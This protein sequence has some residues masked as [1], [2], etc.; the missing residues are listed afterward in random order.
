MSVEEA[1]L[2]AGRAD[3]VRGLQGS[4]DP[5][6][7]FGDA[8]VFIRSVSATHAKEGFKATIRDGATGA[9]RATIEA[10]PAASDVAISADKFVKVG[11]WRDGSP[12]LV[13]RTVAQAGADGLK[14][15][16]TRTTLTMYA[17]SGKVLGT[18]EFDGDVHQDPIVWDGYLVPSS[19]PYLPIGGGAEFRPPRGMLYEHAS[20]AENY[21]REPLKYFLHGTTECGEPGWCPSKLVVRDMFTDKELWGTKSIPV[22]EP[23]RAAAAGKAPSVSVVAAREKL[24]LLA[25][26]APSGGATTFTAHDPATGRLISQGPTT[27]PGVKLAGP[28][29]SGVALSPDG[30]IAVVALTKGAVAWETASGRKLWEQAADERQLRPEA[31]SPK[32]VL[33]ALLDGGGTAALDAR[34]HA[35]LAEKVPTVPSFGDTFGVVR[36][37]SGNAYFVF[38]VAPPK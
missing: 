27:P 26:T 13:V 28:T 37:D 1:G 7:A 24:L 25:W 38:P 29:K 17:P 6:C 11:Y 32:G 10:K 3:I 35:L 19:G 12:A 23:I 22:P 16:T 30:G 8:V 14:A 2:C 18:S 31:V 20:P 36:E 9:E 33:Y 4:P 15:A 34:T 5:A 21:R